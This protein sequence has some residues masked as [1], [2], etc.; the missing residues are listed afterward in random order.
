MWS[1][2]FITDSDALLPLLKALLD[3]VASKKFIEIYNLNIVKEAL[4]MIKTEMEVSDRLLYLIQD[5]TLDFRFQLRAF[6][7]SDVVTS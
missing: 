3:D 5:V 4:N 1:L 6:S 2:L 7:M